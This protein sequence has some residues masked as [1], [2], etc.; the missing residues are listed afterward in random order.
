VD[1]LEQ[2]L[3]GH[4]DRVFV[5]TIVNHARHGAP[6]GYHG[7]RF[8][9]EYKNWPS[10]YLH[11]EAVEASIAKD[12]ARGRKLGPFSH[13]PFKNFVGS[14]M[15]AF[16]R[17]TVGKYRVIYDLSWPPHYSINDHID[18]DCSVHYVSID[19]AINLVKKYGKGTLMAKLDLEDAF[20]FILVHKDDWELLG[21][22]WE[23][24]NNDGT[25][26]KEYY[27]DVVLPFGSKSSPR[28]FNNF[29]CALEYIMYNHNVS[30]VIHYMDDYFTVGPANTA[31]CKNNLENMINVCQEAGFSI[32]PTKLVSPTNTLEFLGIEIDSVSMTTRIT[33]K[34]LNKILLE[35]E[36]FRNRIS[37]KKRDLLSLI[38]KLIFVS[39]VVRAGR[40]FTRRLIE[41]SKKVKYLHHKIKLN[42]DCRRDIVWWEKY[43]PFWNGKY[44]FFDEQST[45]NIDIHLHTDASHDGYGC[46]FHAA[47][48]MNSFTETEKAKTITWK[49]LYAIVI[50]CNTWGYLLCGKR[51]VFHCDNM[52]VVN[53]IQCG[54]SK[55]GEIMHLVRTLFYVCAVYNM[56]CIAVHV[57][58]IKNGVADALSRGQVHRFR[59]LMPQADGTATHHKKLTDIYELDY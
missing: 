1:Y 39:K 32:Q 10:A 51:V 8:Y 13:P 9:R 46:S 43:L 33:Q 53:I 18:I 37:C 4:P 34:R 55:N 11:R 49:E 16:E 25:H 42:K 47:W 31:I 52:A 58:G 40:T 5:D 57:P 36:K 23:R 12:I 28:L 29:A 20:K 54:V 59:D 24:H 21:T 3:S 45:S 27:V 7:P 50:A 48:I 6:I 14:P 35:L 38:G 17:S 30:D 15:G 26:T 2:C 19:T 41:L 22:T 44:M 56:E